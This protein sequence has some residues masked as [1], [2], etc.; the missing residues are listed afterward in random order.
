MSQRKELLKA[1]NETCEAASKLTAAL[2]SLSQIA[3]DIYGEELT[4]DICGG[5]EVEFRRNCERGWS[6]DFD[7]IRLEYLLNILKD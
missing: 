5:Y 2:E 7:C 6:D 3:T 1:Y 4:A